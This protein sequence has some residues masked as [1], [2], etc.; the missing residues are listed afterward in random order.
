MLVLAMTAMAGRAAENEHNR[1]KAKETERWNVK[2]VTADGEPLYMGKP[3][4]HWMKSMRDRD[5]EMDLALGALTD[6]GPDARQAVPELT[7]IVAEPFTPIKV[8]VDS[9]ELM[10]SKLL[11]IQRRGDAIDALTAIGEPAASSSLPLIRW[12]LAVRVIPPSVA[13][14]EDDNMFV[15]LVAIDVLQRMRVAG[16]IAEF[17]PDAL[18]AV[19]ALLA[20]SDD[21]KRKLGVAIL[22]ENALPIAAALLKSRNCEEARLGIAILVDMWPVVPKEHLTTLNSKSVCNAN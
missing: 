20:S 7:R 19:A 4:S 15:N 10:L 17:G 12:A 5:E 22:S 11:D 9:R 18:P 13:N 3:L 14:T 6:L 1:K 21:E 2:G 8:G 16:A